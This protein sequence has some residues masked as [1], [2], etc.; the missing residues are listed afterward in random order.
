[1]TYRPAYR[2]LLAAALLFGGTANSVADTFSVAVQPILPP[3]A[4]KAAYT[5]LMNY[6][7]KKT[8]H[9]FE[10]VTSPNFL[11]YWQEMKKGKYHMILDAAHLADY[12][13]QKMGYKVLAKVLDVVSFTLVTGEDVFAFEPEELVGKRIASLASPS[14][15]ALTLDEFFKNPIRQPILVEVTNAQDAVQKVLDK[16]ADGAIIPTPLL[17]GFPDLNVVATQDQWPHMA[18]SVSQDIPADAAT[19]IQTALI[20]AANDPQGQKMLEAVN[21]PGFEKAD[22]TVYAGYS[23]ILKGFW[24]F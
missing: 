3:K 7:G 10:L 5:P 20:E 2:L 16:K 4:T 6:L 12:R 21:F 13:A 19:S 14:R 8:G 15:G 22:A 9:K 1:M 17:G 18:I 11:S 23:D 24:G